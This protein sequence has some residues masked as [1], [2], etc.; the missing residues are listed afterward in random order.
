MTRIGVG[1]VATL[2]GRSTFSL[3]A[4]LPALTS[5][6]DPGVTGTQVTP[7]HAI[8]AALAATPDH[9]VISQ[10]R[11]RGPL[12]ANDEFVELFNP[13][14]AAVSIGG[15]KLKA[16][17]ATA[18][19]GTRATVPVGVS[20]P[21][22]GYYLFTNSSVGGY[23]GSVPGNQQYATG[24]PDNGALGITL[25]TDQVVDA[26]GM[27]STAVLVEGTPLP[28]LGS[29]NIDRGYMR[30]LGA[31]GCPS[32]DTNDNAADFVLVVPTTPRNANSPA[33][34]YDI[35][36]GSGAASPPTVEAG[37]SSLLSVTV[38]PAFGSTGL[39]ILAD[40][41]AIGGLNRQ[42]FFDDGQ[43]GDLMAADNVFSF[44]AT[45]LVDVAPGQKSLHVTIGDDQNRMATTVIQLTVIPPSNRAPVASAGGPY[46]GAE[47]A[48]IAFNATVSSDPDGDPL[49]YDWDF[50]DGSTSADAGASPSHAYA[51]NGSYTVSV[52]VRDDHDHAVTATASVAVSNVAPALSA[53][54]SAEIMRGETWSASGQFSDPGADTHTG[55]V[56]WGDGSSAALGLSGQTFSLSH[57]YASAGAFTVTVTVTDDDGGAGTASAIVTV[58]S[59]AGATQ[60]LAG[61]VDVL[62]ANGD[63]SP[64]TAGQLASSLDA[65]LASL[66]RDNSAAASGQLGAFIN[67]ARAAMATGKISDAAGEALIAY[68]IR[69]LAS[70]PG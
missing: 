65:A 36:V 3:L 19:V 37:G 20:I 8:S 38:T 67:K 56:N 50:G 34:P 6:G 61:A 41:T 26:V 11:I 30:R 48:T 33:C 5:C 10:F 39:T 64:Q 54:A 23:T 51:D 59:P 18:V 55:A 12:F 21:P 49:T 1:G 15:W 7:T 60:S 69:I 62:L 16:A 66:V 35:I 25:P 28:V 40:L 63:I 42:E 57:T 70:I 52:T 47:G 31:D 13:T 27:S 46:A 53:I 24:I 44:V 58:L 45:V 14:S 68:A 22:G 29:A 17:T 2:I 4:L 43:N 9:V 32:Q